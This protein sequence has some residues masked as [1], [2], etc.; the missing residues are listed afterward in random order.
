[1]RA[2]DRAGTPDTV[3]ARYNFTPEQM[4]RRTI[5]TRMYNSFRDGTKAQIEMTA[6]ANMAGLVP[7]VRGMH[8]P[9]VTLEQIPDRFCH[10]A[11]GG[12]LSR[13]GVVELANSVDA[14]GVSP[15]PHSLG[16]GVF[17]VIRTDHPYTQEDLLDYM[18]FAGSNGRTYLLYRPYHLVAVTAPL[19]I[20]RAVLLH[21]ATGQPLPVPMAETVTAA[22]RDLAAGTVLD[23]GGGYTVVGLCERASMAHQ[24]RLLPLGLCKGATLKEAVRAEGVITRDMVELPSM[25]YLHQLRAEQDQIL[26]DEEGMP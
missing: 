26:K 20:L 7:D 8:E 17:A 22:K 13:E 16:M 1:M 19:S 14:D 12:L 9:A 24:H 10:Q 25:T 3:P 15:L 18:G 4:A 2:D 23:G 21:E 11:D 5:N 6:L